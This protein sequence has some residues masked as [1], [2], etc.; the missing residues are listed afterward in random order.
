LNLE[1]GEKFWVNIGWPCDSVMSYS[2]G[3]RTK[4]KI[5]KECK[6]GLCLLSRISKTMNKTVVLTDA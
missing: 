5:G 3:N 2:T 1:T 6:F 4:N